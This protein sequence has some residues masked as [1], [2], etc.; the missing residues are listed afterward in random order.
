MGAA[1][2]P[3]LPLNKKIWTSTFALFSSGTALLIFGVFYF[4][5]EV[6]RWRVGCGPLLVFGTNAIFA[7]TISSVLTVILDR[8]RIG[9]G[10]ADAGISVHRWLYQ[11]VFARWMT[12]V[13][14]SLAYA[15]GIV[16]LN[17]AITYPLYRKKVFLRI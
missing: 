12:P 15:V 8:W 6:R 16:L 3:V 7:F 2:Q 1:L 5:V 13:H 4:A 9:A 10:G 17:L 14:A 11:E